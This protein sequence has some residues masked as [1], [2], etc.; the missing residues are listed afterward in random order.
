[1]IYNELYNFCKVRDENRVKF[2]NRARF[3]I[4]LL[5]R[6]GIEHKVVRTKSLFYRKYFYNIYCFGSSDKF[7][8]AHYDVVDINADNANDNSASVIN[9]IAYKQKNPS[10]NLIILDGEEPP[11]MGAGSKFAS[12]YLK[13]NNIPVKWILNLELTGAGST[14]F[15][16]DTKTELA[17]CINKNFPD[18]FSIGTPFNDAIVFRQY[19]FQSNVITCV[20][21]KEDIISKRTGWPRTKWDEDDDEFE[22]RIIP[23]MSPLYDSHSPKDSVDKMSIEDMKK[24]VN[25]VVDVIVKKC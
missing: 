19:G 7:L 14:F 15:I 9:C 13:A 1:M 4:D 5:T 10:I 3:L 12:K 6:L 21:P 23:D 24:F 16:D 20:N 11:Y 8:S 22:T 2:S 18:S 17:S 25:N